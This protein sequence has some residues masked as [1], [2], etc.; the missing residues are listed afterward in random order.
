M[1]NCRLPPLRAYG[2]PQSI[3]AE[4]SHSKNAL[5]GPIQKTST[6]PRTTSL[7][8]LASTRPMIYGATCG[9]RWPRACRHAKRRHML[10]LLS[11][12]LELRVGR[13]DL[14]PRKNLQTRFPTCGALIPKRPRATDAAVSEVYEIRD[15]RI[16]SHLNLPES[17]L[18]PLQ[19]ASCCRTHVR[20]LHLSGPQFDTR[21]HNKNGR[22]HRNRNRWAEHQQGLIT[23]D[24]KPKML[25]RLP[26]TRLPT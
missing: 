22:Y 12:V 1:I 8:V 5:H 13:D 25:G 26:L 15:R 24:G 21:K 16:F 7:L 20:W 18:K 23:E 9:S 6:A 2:T 14:R 3:P 19:I 10:C 11:N 4:S 17:K